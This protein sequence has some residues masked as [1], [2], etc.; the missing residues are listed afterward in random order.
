MIQ[1]K[2]DGGDHDDNNDVSCID[3]FSISPTFQSIISKSNKNTAGK[4]VDTA[5][6]SAERRRPRRWIHVSTH[7]IIGIATVHMS[8]TLYNI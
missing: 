2:T 3:A 5:A 6:V 4:R 7:E 1:Q 8:N